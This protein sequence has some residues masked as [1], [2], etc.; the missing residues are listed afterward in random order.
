MTA[1]VVY[2]SLEGHTRTVAHK[3]ASELG[4]QLVELV[5]ERPYATEGPAKFLRSSKDTIA[6][7]R[8]ALRPY[9]FP[10][11]A[12]LVVLCAPCWAGKPAAP[13]NTFLADHDLAGA[14]RA[15]VI[16]EKA[17]Q[18]AAKYGESMRRVCGL[19]ADDPVL[20]ISEAQIADAGEFARL[21]SD[22]AEKCRAL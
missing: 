21:V 12:D 16:T 1:A 20:S 7:V 6:G 9:D 8:P 4:A 11:G 5:C 17:G 19:G 15:A 18:A 2:Y 14:R 10:A 22:F 3:I 13:L